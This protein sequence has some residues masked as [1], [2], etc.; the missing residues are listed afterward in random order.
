MA[1]LCGRR[2]DIFEAHERGLSERLSA[3]CCSRGQEDETEERSDRQRWE[4]SD[5]PSGEK[6]NNGTYNTAGASHQ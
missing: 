1:A 4:K 3:G 6:Q 5:Q 2:Q